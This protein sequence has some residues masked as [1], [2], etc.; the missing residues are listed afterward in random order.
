MEVF[1]YY[2]GFEGAPEIIITQKT[3][4][5]K[6]VAI[7]KLWI[8]YFDTIVNLIKPNEN[9]HWEGV[10]LHYNLL[11]GWHDGK[12]WEC[13]DVALFLQQIESIYDSELKSSEPETIEKVSLRFWRN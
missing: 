11:S 13:D 9:G 12:P 7:L 6:N 8:A 4:N 2:S 3:R 1:D 5:G 10:T